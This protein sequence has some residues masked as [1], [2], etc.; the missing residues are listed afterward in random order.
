[1]SEIKSIWLLTGS[2]LGD[3][4][5]CLERAARDIQVTIGRLVRASALYETEAWGVENQ[6]DYYNQALEIWTAL[7]PTEVLARLHEIEHNLGRVRQTRWGSRVIDI[8]LL[9]Y[10]GEIVDTPELQVPHPRIQKR[11]FVLV[12][13]AEIAPDLIHPIFK[14]TI[15]TLLEES[16]DPCKVR[17]ARVPVFPGSDG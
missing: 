3:R 8:D 17:K 16:D 5:A 10:A 7:P 1:M 4:Q 9:F 6:P 15:K 2:N 14:K 11:N 12:P 13:M